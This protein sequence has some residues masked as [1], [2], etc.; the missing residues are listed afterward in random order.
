[1]IGSPSVDPTGH[2]ARGVH[3]LTVLYDAHCPLCRAAH[4]WLAAR[5]QLVPL[6]F[7]PAGSDEAR[8]RLP[9]LDHGATLRDVTVVA[10][11]GEVYVG[12][13]AWLACLWA[14]AGY[15]ELAERLARPHLLPVARRVIA[16]AAAVRERTRGYGDDD[17]RADCADDRCG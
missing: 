3:A 10:D 9:G 11:T 14:L 16:A 17:D 4:R 1:M 6:E 2:G 12:D 5:D 13:G 8:R 15:R 7:V